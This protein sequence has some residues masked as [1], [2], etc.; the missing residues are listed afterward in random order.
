MTSHT[1]ELDYTIR[2][3]LSALLSSSAFSHVGRMKR[4]LCH[5][6]EET[7][8]GR[9]QNLTEYQIGVEVFDRAPSFDPGKD[10][11]VRVHGRRLR[12]RLRCYYE[13]ECR[14]GQIQIELPE[15][16]YTPV[17]RRLGASSLKHATAKALA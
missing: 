17:M 8:A 6:V 1:I 12:S 11:I 13:E 15:G 2:R 10:P 9:Y 16:S 5:I 3:H 4:F 14:N 7:L